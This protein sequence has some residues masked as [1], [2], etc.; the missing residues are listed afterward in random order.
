[1]RIKKKPSKILKYHNYIVHQ[2]L[3]FLPKQPIAGLSSE[4][5]GELVVFPAGVDLGGTLRKDDLLLLL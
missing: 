5:A 3:H 2:T 1:M 4:G